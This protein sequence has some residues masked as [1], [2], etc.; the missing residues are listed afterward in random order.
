[1]ADSPLPI[2]LDHNATT[3][4]APEAFEAMVPWLRD[5]FG[6]PSS[7]HVYGRR[8]RDAIERA[9]ADVAALLG[10][11]PEEIVFTSGGTEAN[12]LAILGTVSAARAP[13]E[14][15]VVTTQI[16]HPATSNPCRALR[17]RGFSVVEVEVD[18]AGKVDVDAVE[19]ALVSAQGSV[20]FV[21]VMHANN[22]TG[23]LQPVEEI[24][25][26]AK[27]HGATVHADAAQSI[28]KVAVDVRTLGVDLLSVAGHK[29]YAPPG[30]GAL[31][32]RKGV[33]LSP[34]L[35]GAGHE[36]GLRPGT[37]NVPGMV[38]LGAACRLAQRT[39]HEEASRQRALRERMHE[40]LRAGVKGL[41]LSGHPTERLPNT[42]N[43]R[44]PGV[45]GNALLEAT[46]GIAASTGSACHG[47]QESASSVQ[48]AMGLDERD[49]LGAVR[50][51]LGRSTTREQVET[52]AEE[53]VRAY[54]A[55]REA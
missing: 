42:L 30:I 32:I 10:A 2:Y 52:A 6:N 39:L 28:G 13:S 53:L 14:V 27:G 35:L 47:G 18:R 17:T 21:T 46:P 33:K 37:E 41:A 3:P 43:V 34:Y 51:T 31:F 5:H 48:L 55:L 1:M 23:T 11:E 19:A 45:R 44:F 20:P 22:E 16:E 38:A 8:G 26:R 15:H 40:R 50:L 49:A 24:A 7:G 36:R 9:R 29:V 4:V 12:N 54:A 25:K